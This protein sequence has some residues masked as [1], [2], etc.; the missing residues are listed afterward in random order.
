MNMPQLAAA[1]PART[2]PQR[3]RHALAD[4]H[5]VADAAPLTLPAAR[6]PRAPGL[7]ADALP[8]SPAAREERRALYVRCLAHYRRS[9]G[10][11]AGTGSRR[12]DDVAEAAAHFVVANLRALQG[13]DAT[14]AVF[15]ALKAQL[16]GVLRPGLAALALREQQDTFEKFALLAVLIGETWTVAL[17]QGPAAMANVRQAA[18]GYLLELLGLE[19][20]RLTLGPG[21]LVAVGG[22]G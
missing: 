8:G 1:G 3:M 22:A 10:A 13:V 12:D 11:S 2:L 21:G 20:Q 7:L 5:A 4:A 19:P 15:D 6:V 9:V 18:R 17:R 14:P 16:A